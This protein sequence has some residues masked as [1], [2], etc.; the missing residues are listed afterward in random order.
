MTVAATRTADPFVSVAPRLGFVGGFDGFRGIGVALVLLAHVLPDNHDSFQP[1]VDGFFV[2]SAFLIMSLLFQEHRQNGRL[3]LKKFYARRALRLLP[4]SY[5]CMA[6]WMLLWVLGSLA[7]DRNAPDVDQAAL[8]QFDAIPGNVAAAALYVY[9][10][11][12]P[13]AGTVG[14]LN[15]FWSLSVEEQFYGV[16]AIGVAWMLV[17]RRRVR[18]AVA[19]FVVAFAYVGWSRF[20]F[21]FGPWPGT[22]YSTDIWSRGLRTLWLARPD[23]FFVGAVLAVLNAR[24]PDPLTPRQKRW[25]V[26]SGSASAVVIVVILLSSLSTPWLPSLPGMP[27]SVENGTDALRCAAEVGGVHEP[28]LDRMWL[29]RWIF[30]VFALA[31]APFTLCLARVKDCGLA[32]FMSWKPFRSLGERSYSLYIWHLLA[33]LLAEIFIGG[34]LE[35]AGISKDGTAGQLASIVGRLAFALVVGFAA[36]RYI[37]RWV[38][39]AKLRFATESVVVDRRTGEE[40]TIERPGRSE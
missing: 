18:W 12:Y 20:R 28:C 37:D 30:T 3:D 25:I 16:V 34:F 23:A 7:F 26:R 31:M 29:V 14:P 39:G 33:Y 1:I 40:V 6:A 10:L 32:K 13:P 17:A 27:K 19:V 38:L 15:Q 11:V 5:A 8:A 36:H 2:I 4:N 35:G 22:L 9:H 21:D 24:L